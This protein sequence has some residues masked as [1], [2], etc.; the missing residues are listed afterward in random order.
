MVSILSATVL[1]ITIML[2]PILAFTPTL[3]G[4]SEVFSTDLIERFSNAQTLGKSDVGGVL[5]P[6]SVTHVG[7]VVIIGLIIALST[8]FYTKKRTSFI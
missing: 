5:F 3:N 1:G 6:S 2:L 8:Y 7:L 4:S